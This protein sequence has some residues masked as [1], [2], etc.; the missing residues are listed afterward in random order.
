MVANQIP[1]SYVPL[2]LTDPQNQVLLSA[3]DPMTDTQLKAIMSGATSINIQKYLDPL[4][5]T[6]DEFEINNLL[7]QAAFLSQVAVES[8]QLRYNLELASGVAYEN[9]KDLG[10]TQPGDGPRFKGRGLIQLTG[11]KNYHDVGQALG[12]DLEHNPE[13]VASDP[14]LAARVAGYFFFSRGLNQVADTGDIL[15]V[16]HKVNGGY[17]GIDQ[18]IAFFQKAID[19]FKQA[20]N[21]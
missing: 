3:L 9:R 2:D 5:K 17:N 6:M 11:R 13:T 19:V 14:E 10:N 18:R 4:N 21:S 15:K 12:L 20:L 8:G 7:R 16:S 1:S